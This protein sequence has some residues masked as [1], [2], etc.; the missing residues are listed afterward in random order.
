MITMYKATAGAG[1]SVGM[2]RPLPLRQ[3]RLRQRVRLLRPRSCLCRGVGLFLGLHRLSSRGLL[4][5]GS[6]GCGSLGRSLLGQLLDFFQLGDFLRLLGLGGLFLAGLAD[7]GEAL[8]DILHA[9]VDVLL[10]VGQGGNGFLEGGLDLVQRL[11]DVLLDLLG[12]SAGVLLQLAQHLA[13]LLCVDGQLVGAD[14]D[15]RDDHD[16]H[17]FP[18]PIFIFFRFLSSAARESGDMECAVRGFWRAP[19]L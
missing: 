16:D 7:A 14:E 12:G 11:H 8:G 5:L 17:E 2:F 1:A 9:V 4:C 6:F 3:V 10:D 18:K 13:Q 19:R 15:E